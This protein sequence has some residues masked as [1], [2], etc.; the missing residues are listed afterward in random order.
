MEQ[1]RRRRLVGQLAAL[2]TVLGELH[3]GG[4]KRQVE[5]VEQPLPAGA[6]GGDRVECRLPAV[7]D[8]HLGIDC[9]V[10]AAQRQVSLE[11][12]AQVVA[13]SYNFV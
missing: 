11:E 1:G 10:G 3:L 6:H 5:V 4:G 13:Q 9:R 7:A 8:Q 12:L 2:N